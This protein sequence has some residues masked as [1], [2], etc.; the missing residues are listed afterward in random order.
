VFNGG[1]G[2]GLISHI[3]W[4]TWGG[5]LAI[6][7]GIGLYI[8]PYQA[9]AEGTRE[10]A[11]IVAFRLGTCHGRRAYD[12]VEWYFPQHGQHFNP[13]P[14]YNLC[15]SYSETKHTPTSSAPSTGPSTGPA[16]APLGATLDVDDGNLAV[17]A[18]VMDPVT[19]D[20]EFE[21]P[22]AGER[23]VAVRLALRDQGAAWIESD[24]NVDATLVGANE[25]AY[26]FAF[27]ESAGCTNF[28]S[29]DYSL[30]PGGEEVGC[31]VYELPEG[32]SVRDVRFGLLNVEAEWS[33]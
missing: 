21:T 23:F 9:S 10:S 17:T 30:A 29:G 24:A 3:H 15:N 22:K 2:S 11:R 6:G 26:T 20:N 5:P 31:V 32:V 28:S 18:S 14:P 1:D 4:K 25:Q 33:E 12:A 8:T 27:A 19:A 16:T 13:R 7:T